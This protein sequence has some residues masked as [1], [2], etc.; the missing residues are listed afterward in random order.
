MQNP[1]VPFVGGCR[2]LIVLDAPAKIAM[3]VIVEPL[4]LLAYQGKYTATV[5]CSARFD[6]DAVGVQ[7]SRWGG[8]RSLALETLLIARAE[9]CHQVRWR[10]QE[11]VDE[12]VAAHAVFVVGLLQPFLAERANLFQQHRLFDECLG[13]VRKLSLRTPVFVTLDAPSPVLAS[14]FVQQAR[15]AADTVVELEDPLLADARRHERMLEGWRR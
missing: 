6:I 4:A 13:L 10:L 15:G 3:Q 14:G 8:D 11:M 5:L 12:P 2:G 7:V 1:L 9:T